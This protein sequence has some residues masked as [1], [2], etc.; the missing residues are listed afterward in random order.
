[1]NPQVPNNGVMVAKDGSPLPMWYRFFN[2]A[3]KLLVALTQSGTTAQEPTT[4]LWVG[5]P[6]FNTDTNMVEFWDGS[7]WVSPGGGGAGAPTNATYVTMSL[8]GVLTNERVL[9]AG[10][11]IT[12]VDGGANGPVTISSTA[13]GGGPVVFLEGE[14]GEDRF[15]LQPSNPVTPDAD[16][17]FPVLFLDPDVGEDGIPGAPGIQ[18]AQGPAGV[19]GIQGM[20]G[21]DGPDGEQGFP[22]PQGPPGVQGPIGPMPA[23]PFI[24]QAQIDIGLRRKKAGTAYIEPLGG[25]SKT[26]VGKPVMVREAGGNDEAEH[27]QL[28]CTAQIVNQRQMKITWMAVGGNGFAAGKR[29]INYLIA[30]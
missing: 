6:Y 21:D 30:A 20:I 19:N 5:R 8:N 9:T 11:G 17:A 7:A 27:V 25:F 28:L 18:G 22:G 15:F 1:M 12:I 24:G 13:T 29:T 4:F 10:T 3:S 26:Q 16:Q 23:V 14:P 2:S